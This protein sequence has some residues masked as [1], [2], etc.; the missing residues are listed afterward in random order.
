MTKEEIEKWNFLIKKYPDRAG[1]AF[2]LYH[3]HK[4][5]NANI[6]TYFMWA[7][8]LERQEE[9]RYRKGLQKYCERQITKMECENG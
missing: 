3:R 1:V 9:R 5:K 2:E 7:G 8:K 4:K 6:T